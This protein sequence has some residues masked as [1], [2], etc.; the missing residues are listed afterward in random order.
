M[1]GKEGEGEELKEKVYVLPETWMKSL[2]EKIDKVCKGTECLPEISKKIDGIKISEAPAKPE[3]HNVFSWMSFCPECGEKVREEP[4]EYV[5][6]KCHVPVDPK[7]D[8]LCWN[9]GSKKAVKKES[10]KI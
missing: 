8:K 4:P 10:L 6:N 3:K 9:C 5:C 7:K 2:D 1:A